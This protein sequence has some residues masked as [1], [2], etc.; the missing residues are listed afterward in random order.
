MQ[1][2]EQGSKKQRL[3]KAFHK[4]NNLLVTIMGSATLG[5]RETKAESDAHRHFSN[6]EEA[7]RQAAELVQEIRA[8]IGLDEREEFEALVVKANEEPAPVTDEAVGDYVLVV[9]DDATIRELLVQMLKTMGREVVAVESGEEAIRAARAH[10]SSL[11]MAMVDLT[12]PGMNGEQVYLE[13]RKVLPDLR[14]V[15]MSGYGENASLQFLEG[16]ASEFLQKPFTLAELREVV[17][18]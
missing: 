9:D 1:D 16:G 12:M 8:L 18:A 4:F 7:S 15:M 14:I 10:P 6:V 2:D 5:K 11:T 13:L 3:Q 17:G